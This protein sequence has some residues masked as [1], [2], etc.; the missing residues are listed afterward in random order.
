MKAKTIIILI[1]LQ[2]IINSVLTAQELLI[3]SLDNKKI[4]Y[5]VLN[6]PILVSW[7]ENYFDHGGLVKIFRKLVYDNDDF[8]K[9]IVSYTID[10][11][12]DTLIAPTTTSTFEYQNHKLSKITTSSVFYGDIKWEADNIL[13]FKYFYHNDNVIDSSKTRIIKNTFE[14]NNI[15]TNVYRE[16]DGK[17]FN[18]EEF[19]YDNK[20]NPF[21]KSEI[22]LVFGDLLV[23]S[24]KNN[25]INSTNLEN[26]TPNW[27]RVIS[28][29]SRD[30]PIKIVT[31]YNNGNIGTQNIRYKTPLEIK[32]PSTSHKY[33]IYPNPTS[34]IFKIECN[35]INNIKSVYLLNLD[36]SILKEMTD[37]EQ[38]NI[39][40][41]AS[42]S[43]FLIINCYDKKI[44]KK[45]IKTAR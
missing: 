21:Y 7:D 14:G 29:N 35:E 30:Y 37:F 27:S 5:N 25:W 2:F 44:I 32:Q 39:G 8:L 26:N 41:F 36:G 23:F 19:K 6:K 45:I 13:E 3:D 43:Y 15:K 10:S 31:D 38:L 9:E 24:S 1:G 22:A 4:E 17:T 18:N 33:E 34:G 20:V 40:E 12:G 42:G 16:L 28:Y 11:K